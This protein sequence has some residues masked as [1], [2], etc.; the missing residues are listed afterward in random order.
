MAGAKVSFAIFLTR[1]TTI[2]HAVSIAA[3]FIRGAA[4]VIDTVSGLAFGS[5]RRAIAFAVL[6]AVVRVFIAL[7]FAVAAAVVAFV[8]TDIGACAS[9]ACVNPWCAG[10]AA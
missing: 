2:G 6:G 3:N 10:L 1:C 5:A 4:Y 8:A 9:L 7:A